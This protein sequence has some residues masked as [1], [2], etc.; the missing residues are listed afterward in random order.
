M[1][2]QVPYIV[3]VNGHEVYSFYDYPGLTRERLLTRVVICPQKE[4]REKPEFPVYCDSQ[5]R[6]HSEF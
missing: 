5:G 1:D 2:K 3:Y 6:E 4:E